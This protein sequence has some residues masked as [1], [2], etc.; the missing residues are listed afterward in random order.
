MI[1]IRKPSRPPKVLADKGVPKAQAHHDEYTNDIQ[2]YKDGTKTFT[3]DRNIYAHESVKKALKRAQ[4]GKCCFCETIVEDDGD[5]EHFRPKAAYRQGA[6]D[7]LVRPGYYWLAYEWSNL[8][9]SCIPCNQRHKKNLFPLAESGRRASNY[10]GMYE[11]LDEEPLFIDPARLDPE[12][13]I[14]FREEV[15]Y[16][17]N[18]NPAGRVTIE[19][20]GLDRDQLIHSRKERFLSM[21]AHYKLLLQEERVGRLLALAERERPDALESLRELLKQIEEAKEM[22]AKARK[23]YGSYSAMIR[24][25]LNNRFWMKDSE[26]AS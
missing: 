16:S 3:F 1:Q 15:P 17:V 14:S 11:V 13:Y 24:A 26:R 8:F 20:L 6:G 23:G 2:S 7:E 4:R 5:V 10:S 21:R 22:M 9:L 25:A 19:A 12:S 18:D